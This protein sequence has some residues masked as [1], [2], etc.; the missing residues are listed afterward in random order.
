M[1]TT[2]R[3]APPAA[4]RSVKPVRPAWRPAPSPAVRVVIADGQSLVR[5]GFRLL[6][7]I[8]GHITV[9]GEA[10]SGE[11]AVAVARRLNPDVALIDARLPGLDS[12]EATRQISSESG[13]KVMLLAASG[14]DEHILAAL[15]AGATGLLLK[16]TEPGELV[17]ALEALARGEA[18]LSPS[19]ARRLIA[20]LASRPEAAHP[21]PDLLDELTAREREVVALVG[22]GLDN[23]EIAEQLVISL[24]TAKT[25]VSR[26]MLKLHA[27]DRAKLVIFAYETGLVRARTE[28]ATHPDLWLTTAQERRRNR[29]AEHAARQADASEQPPLSR[30]GAGVATG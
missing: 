1:T 5:A 4:I 6:L 20:E 17:R 12:V 30:S 22:H 16:D 26:A 23:A 21:R 28:R 2:N 15:R 25:H 19:L 29:Q 24:A 13:V 10:A 9:V 14:C 11:E 7:E 18:L 27:H 8:A 3:F